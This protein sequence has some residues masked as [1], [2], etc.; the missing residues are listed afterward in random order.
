MKKLFFVCI[1]AILASGIAW[2]FGQ[3]EDKRFDKIFDLYAESSPVGEY[4]K[5]PVVDENGNPVLD[6]EGNLQKEEI[7]KGLTV[8]YFH[9]FADKYEKSDPDLTE[10]NRAE[11]EAIKNGYIYTKGDYKGDVKVT[12][13]EPEKNGL[14]YSII[15]YSQGG[16]QA[17]GYLTQL[18]KENSNDVE[19]IDAVITVSGA[20]QGVKM[21]DGGLGNFKRKLSNIIN[22]FGNGL[23]AGVGV[24]DVLYIMGSTVFLR[25][26]LANIATV[27]FALI[28]PWW[29]P[30]WA[31]AWVYTDP[32]WV[33]QI[34]DMIPGSDYIKNNVVE[35]AP[36]IVSVKTG[37]KQIKEWRSITLGKM[38]IW[39]YYTG[40]EDI[41]TEYTLYN[42]KD[43]KPKFDPDV[44]V[45]FIAGLDSNTLSMAADLDEPINLQGHVNDLGDFFEG[46]KITHI[47]KSCLV[48]GLI[49]GSPIYAKDAEKA[50]NLMRNF[51]SELNNM[52]GSK[53]NDG[54][55]A[56]ESQYIPPS[57]LK[58]GK[59][60]SDPGG[61]GYIPMDKNNHDNIIRNPKTY[62]EAAKMINAG[63]ELRGRKN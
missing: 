47:I 4:A 54:F 19:D 29:R 59:V 41:Y 8:Y 7:L 62:E 12:K 37:E 57:A 25:D 33:P 35:A 23:R 13:Y 20:V 15:G 63:R 26:Q 44:P 38:K 27:F 24:F 32:E 52:K 2:G 55:I 9:G 31:D 60:L 18:K 53:Q 10:I 28:P 11:I 36:K 5:R 30:Y 40:K 43:V 22:T 58:E 50:Q 42:T 45:G 16:L 14:G 48:I 17:L 51:N 34:R 61:K 1:A 49:S 6:E 3:T 46:V 39:Y 56:L 21:L